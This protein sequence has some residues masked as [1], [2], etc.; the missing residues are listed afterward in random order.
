N[1][2]VGP[3]E[4][5]RGRQVI[6]GVDPVA[7]DAFTTRAFWTDPGTIRHIRIAHELGAGEMD[8]SKLNIREFEA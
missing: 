8:L 4:V 6:A 1:G 5:R 2:P 7:I 3:G